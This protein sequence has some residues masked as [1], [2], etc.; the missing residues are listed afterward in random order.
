MGRLF[1]QLTLLL[2]LI[3][4]VPRAN[5]DESFT[6]MNGYVLLSPPS[7][8]FTKLNGYA[9]L[10]ASATT[11][12]KMNSYAI[13]GL[14]VNGPS[15][16]KENG[17]A[18]LNG[19]PDSPSI[20]KENGYAVLNGTPDKPSFVKMNSYAVIVAPNQPTVFIFTRNDNSP[21]RPFCST[22]AQMAFRGFPRDTRPFW[23]PVSGSGLPVSSGLA[24]E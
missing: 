2:L 23:T 21:D 16:A 13:V 12:T 15:I 11:F 20:T 3:T 22:N 24:Q 6:K 9:I 10:G 19:A 18:V 4:F 1:K 5:G 14:Y 8:T 7:P 17:Y